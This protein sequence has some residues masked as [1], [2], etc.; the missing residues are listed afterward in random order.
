MSRKVGLPIAKTTTVVDGTD[1]VNPDPLV[2]A[3]FEKAEKNNRNF[4]L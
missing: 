4:L 2:F 3:R 1:P